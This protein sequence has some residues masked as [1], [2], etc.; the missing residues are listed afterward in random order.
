MNAESKIDTLVRRM[1]TFD[2]NFDGYPSMSCA[3]E[4]LIQEAIEERAEMLFASDVPFLCFLASEVCETPQE[5]RNA[6]AFIDAYIDAAWSCNMIEGDNAAYA[7][8]EEEE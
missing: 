7:E 4:G 8:M 1:R 3:D 2:G 5:V 6:R